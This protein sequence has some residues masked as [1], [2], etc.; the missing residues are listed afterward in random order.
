MS[1]DVDACVQTLM[2]SWHFAIPRDVSGATNACCQL[3]LQLT[4]NVYAERIGYTA[5]TQPLGFT[6]GL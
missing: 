5:L 1:K 2:S 4:P 6:R 3:S